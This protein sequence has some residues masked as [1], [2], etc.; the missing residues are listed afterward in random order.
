M[1][2]VGAALLLAAG[3]VGGGR[4]TPASPLVP[5]APEATVELGSAAADFCYDGEA[6]LA[7]ENSGTRIVRYNTA[8]SVLD[9]IPLTERVTAPIGITADRFYIYV[10]DSQTLYRTSRDRLDLQPWFGEVRVGGLASFEPGMVLVSDV[11]RGE[12]W[13]KG[14]F[15][16]SRLFISAAEISRPGAMVALE[17]GSFAVLSPASRLVHFF[18]R[19]GVVTGSLSLPA[20]CDLLAYDRGTFCIGLRGKPEV[21]VLEGRR[22]AGYSLPASVSP[23]SLAVVNNRLFVLDAGIRLG[24]YSLPAGQ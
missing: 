5:L 12:I 18:N 7:L 21:W 8:L 24:S 2:A 6:L 9:T 19:S 14:L 3:C 10:Y 23:S 1:A 11:D 13:S 15:G 22:L 4:V 17:N 20:A 16:E